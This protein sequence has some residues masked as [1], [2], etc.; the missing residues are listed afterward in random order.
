MY[1]KEKRIVNTINRKQN[2][3]FEIMNSD[4]FKLIHQNKT[5]ATQEKAKKKKYT[6]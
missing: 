2:V 3:M 5:S 6:N 4:S 1:Q